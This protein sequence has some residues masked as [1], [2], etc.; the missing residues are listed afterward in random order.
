M[1]LGFLVQEVV[2]QPA[3]LVDIAEQKTGQVQ[4]AFVIIIVILIVI[5]IIIT[6]VIHRAQL[7]GTVNSKRSTNNKLINLSY[8]S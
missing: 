5:I 4:L 1:L 3:V 7:V 2:L 8:P 6:V